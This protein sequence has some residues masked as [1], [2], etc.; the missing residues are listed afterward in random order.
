MS[1]FNKVTHY[2][3]KDST[4]EDF[5]VFRFFWADDAPEDVKLVKTFRAPIGDIPA[6]DNPV[7]LLEYINS[8]LTGLWLISTRVDYKAWAKRA[9][10]YLR[11]VEERDRKAQL[12]EKI[13]RLES[14]LLNL[15]AEFAELA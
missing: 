6:T 14:E 1:D 5:D 9:L 15:R 2:T 10:E 3:T 8:W 4:G 11:S 12:L 7:E 13:E